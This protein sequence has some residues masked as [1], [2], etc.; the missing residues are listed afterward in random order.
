MVLL[1]ASPRLDL[2]RLATAA[3]WRWGERV[4][5]CTTAGAIGPQ[6]FEEGGL[7]AVGVP[8]SVAR[9]EPLLIEPLRA[10]KQDELARW[11]GR[12]QQ[13]S[14]GGPLAAIT[15]IDGLCQ[16]EEALCA[17][18]EHQLVQIPL[19]GGSAGDDFRY[20]SAPVL[21]DGV[22][23]S[24]R[25]VL[26]GLAF[27]NGFQPRAFQIRDFEP[28][29]GPLVITSATP[30]KRLIHEIDGE[31]AAQLYARRI[32]LPP[33]QL[34]VHDFAMHSMM[35]MVG[36]E[37]YIRS[38]RSITEGGSISMH[39]AIDEGMVVRIGR[40]EDTGASLR[41]RL[42]RQDL[43]AGEVA[44]VLVFDCMHRRM[45]LRRQGHLQEIGAL[46]AK[47][48]AAGFTTYGEVY[49]GLHVNQTCTG[50]VIARGVHA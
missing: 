38:V 4:V 40:S 43:L 46:L 45:E 30:E 37:T 47:A 13:R 14:E 48:P 15:L 34:N 16:R 25:A 18:L 32:G 39:S 2:E 6:G 41:Q 28:T 33:E 20:R 9:V 5:G 42:T 49:G 7:V 10:V 27:Q 35:L 36:G 17:E 31:P 3:T 22:F 21:A 23:R 19:V 11:R 26:L 12:L 50:I 1:F 29:S 44:G 24:D 8:S